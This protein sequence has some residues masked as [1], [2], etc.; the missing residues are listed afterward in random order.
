[1][2]EKAG[3]GSQGGRERKNLVF[4]LRCC[5]IS[6]FKIISNL[7]KLCVCYVCLCEPLSLHVYY[8]FN[9]KTCV[10]KLFM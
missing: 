1:M 7:E 2:R 6:E 3:L 8:R 10:F 9:T 4:D 5:G